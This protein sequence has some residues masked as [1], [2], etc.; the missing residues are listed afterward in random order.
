MN[1]SICLDDITNLT[2]KFTTNCNH[3]FHE[4]CMLK[5]VNKNNNLCPI[6]RKEIITHTYLLRLGNENISVVLLD[7][8]DNNAIVMYY[9]CLIYENEIDDV[10]KK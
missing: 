7:K 1:C 2:T 4:L 9:F 5:C 10:F 8:Y 6:C 3:T